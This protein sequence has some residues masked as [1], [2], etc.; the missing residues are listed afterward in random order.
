M[1]VLDH[2]TRPAGSGA[3]PEEAAGER[4]QPFV[5]TRR[6]FIKGRPPT[7]PPPS[8][9]PRRPRPALAPAPLASP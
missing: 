1:D 5:V 8:N 3:A 7:L 6:S 9:G 2:E 4:K